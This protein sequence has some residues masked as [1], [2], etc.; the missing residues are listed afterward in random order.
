MSKAQVRA[1]NISKL[2]NN[3]GNNGAL[4]LRAMQLQL[5]RVVAVRWSHN[6]TSLR[7]GRDWLKGA[8]GTADHG[9]P[10]CSRVRI[11]GQGTISATL[12]FFYQGY[13]D[14]TVH[15]RQSTDGNAAIW[16]PVPLPDG[17]SYPDA[18][19]RLTNMSRQGEF[20]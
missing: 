15:A 12:T 17:W 13:G 7:I 5:P 19:G 16:F 4:S 2:L 1:R 20:S 11:E 14:V 3:L 8:S 10:A 18:A 9:W 6:G